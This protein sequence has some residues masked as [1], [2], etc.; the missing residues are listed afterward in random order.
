[1]FGD[2]SG[3]GFEFYIED[4]SVF[5]EFIISLGLV[6]LGEIDI[7]VFFDGG[8]CCVGGLF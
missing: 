5:Y 4:L 6:G 3:E 2:E 7:C 8:D 1:M